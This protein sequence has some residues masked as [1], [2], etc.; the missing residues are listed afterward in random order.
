M[1]IRQLRNVVALAEYRSFGKA[2][3]VLNLSQSAL[4]ISVKNLEGEVGA[5]IFVRS[6]K[7]IV[8]TDFGAE[9]LVRAR[10][11]LREVEKTSELIQANKGNVT[12]LIRVGIDSIVAG[13]A[14]KKVTPRFAAA[15]PNARLEVDVATGH[16]SEAQRKLSSG[17]WDLG[18]VLSPESLSTPPGFTS[19]ICA[20]LT[21]YAYARKG[22]PLAARRKITLEALAGQTWVL[23]TR[24]AGQAVI[25]ACAK[26]GLK[27]PSI[28][29][30]VN[31]FESLRGLIET[32]DWVTI[33]PSEIVSRYYSDS[34]ARLYSEEF[35]FR[36][37]LVVLH[38]RDLEMTLPARTLIDSIRDAISIES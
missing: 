32:T 15:F 12:R 13:P 8:P 36:S 20:R 34:F 14:L 11:V 24:T 6:R 5:S 31:S 23:S 9:F 28:V 26:V 27:G 37:N 3:A 1:E 10:S 33:L 4:S 21:T 18:V 35:Q 16:V 30:R 17:D 25:S 38:A 7:E 29:A 22:H 2:A 19:T